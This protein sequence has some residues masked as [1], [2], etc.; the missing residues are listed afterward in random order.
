MRRYS[1]DGATIGITKAD[2]RAAINAADD[3]ANTNTTSYNTA[4]P[5]PARTS[6][7]TA[8]KALLLNFVITRRYLTGV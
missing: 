7:T 8:Q 5:L 2:L 4:L 3:W 1:S 6:L